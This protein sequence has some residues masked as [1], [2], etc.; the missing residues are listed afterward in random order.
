[1]STPWA[2]VVV[3][4]ALLAVGVDALAPSVPHGTGLV[5]AILSRRQL[6]AATLPVDPEVSLS[7]RAFLRGEPSLPRADAGALAAATAGKES[8]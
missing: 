1:V 7:V 8:E 2:A 5:A 6:T 3:T 4:L